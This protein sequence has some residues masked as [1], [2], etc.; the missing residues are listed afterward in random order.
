MKSVSA[1]F[2][3][4]KKEEKQE[5][6]KPNITFS[7]CGMFTDVYKCQQFNAKTGYGLDFMSRISRSEPD[8]SAETIDDSIFLLLAF[9]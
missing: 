9:L 5:R 6:P 7:V 4:S 3:F 8:F 1:N 2:H